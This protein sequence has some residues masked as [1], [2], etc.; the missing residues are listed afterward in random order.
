MGQNVTHFRSSDVFRTTALLYLF[1]AVLSGK[2][3]N[4]LHGEGVDGSDILLLAGV[5]LVFEHHDAAGEADGLP[6]NACDG[7]PRSHAHV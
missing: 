1:P 7:V 2:F 6:E 3:I 4:A 5:W